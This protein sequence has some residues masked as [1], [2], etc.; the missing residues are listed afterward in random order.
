MDDLARR[1]FAMV[2]SALFLLPLGM[3]VPREAG[4]REV[5]RF[6][7]DAAGFTVDVV[8]PGTVAQNSLV[9]PKYCYVV[10][11]SFQVS[12]H[13]KRDMRG[14]EDLRLDL[15]GDG[16]FEW[17]F[18]STGAGRFGLQDTIANG[19]DSAVL[20]FASPGTQ[21]FMV[22]LPAG[23]AVMNATVDVTGMMEDVAFKADRVT[24]QRAFDMLGLAVAGVGDLNR[25]GYDDVAVGAPGTDSKTFTDNGLF[26][27][28]YGSESGPQLGT[29]D[30]VVGSETGD[31][32]G[33]SL[34][35]VRDFNGDGFGEV[36]VGAPNATHRGM[37]TPTPNTGVAYLYANDGTKLR[38]LPA[39][40]IPGGSTG[41]QMGFSV[42]ELGDVDG[43]G[44]L[45]IGAGEIFANRSVIQPLVGRVGVVPSGPSGVG[46]DLWGDTAYSFFGSFITQA[47]DLDSD[48]KPDFVVGAK[49]NTPSGGVVGRAFVYLSGQDFKNPTVFIG[50]QQLANFSASGATGDFNGD[51]F[52]D[53]ALGA[54]NFTVDGHNV[55]A[56]FIYPGTPR[57]P[58][59]GAKPV[60]LLGRANNSGYG[61]SVASPGDLD[62]DGTDD[63]LV[64]IPRLAKDMFAAPL[65]ALDLILT[66]R[67]RTITLWGEAPNSNFGYS[68]DGAGDVNRDGFRDIIVGAPTHTAGS[69]DAAGLA[70]IFTSQIAAPRN[71]RINVG[72]VGADDWAWPGAFART[73]RTPDMAKKFNG[74]LS[75]PMP[76]TVDD[77]GNAFVE[78]PV[79][80]S[81]DRPG[82]VVISN[83]SIVYNW[84]ATVDVNPNEETG[85]LTWALNNI[86]YP[87][88]MGSPPDIEIP[89]VFNSSSAGTVSVH[90]LSVLIDESPVAKPEFTVEL[91]EDSSDA[92]LVDLFTVFA[93]DF[94]SPE[95]LTFW[96]EGYTNDTLVAVDITDWRWLS[97]DAFNGSANDNWTGGVRIEVSAMDDNWLENYTNITVVVTP[98]N[99]PPEITGMP[100]T[101]AT[102]GAPYSYQMAA[103]D[104]ENDTLAF[105]LASGPAGMSVDGA[106]G[107]VKWTPNGEQYNR[108]F[109]V[110][111]FASDGRLCATQSFSI[112]VS[113]KLEGVKIS[114]S[115]PPTAVVGQEYRYRPNATT[116]V[117]GAAVVLSLLQAPAGMVIQAD[118]SLRWV[119]SES[120]LGAFNIT[121]SASDGSFNATLP[122]TVRVFPAG[123]PVSGL[124]C[125]IQE[126]VEG[127]KVSGKLTVMGS[128]G[129]V[130]GTVMR[131]ELS[132]DG[133]NWKAATG[134]GSW[135]YVLDTT[136][137]SNG[138]HT[139]RARA[140]DGTVYSMNASVGVEVDNPPVSTS[141]S[142]W[143]LPILLIIA[144]V[145]AA[146]V[147]A[148]LYT[149]RGRTAAQAAPAALSAPAV[150]PS[151]PAMARTGEEFAV[152]D[153]FLIN[154]DGRLIHHATR[155]LATGV[156]SDIL[157]S[158]LT[159]VNSFV[160][161]ALVRTGDGQLGS[162]EFGENKII[163]ERGKACYLAVVITGRQEPPELREEMRQAL[164]NVES[165]YGSA[166][167]SWD[168]NAAT[169]SGVKKF[170]GPVTAFSL[171]A[172]PAGPAKAAEVDVAVAGELEFYQGYVRLKV[173]VKNSSPSFIMDSALSVMYNDKALR[174][175]RLEPEY[176]LS[177]REIM[178]GNI[179]I[180][181]KKTVALY[182]DPQICTESYVEATLTFKDA[183]GELHHADM[184]RKLASVVCPIMHTDEN[185]NL[186]MLRR[187]LEGDLDQKDSKV[188]N[189]PPALTPEAAFELCKRAVQGHDIRLVREFSD[190]K[191]FVGEAWYFGKVKG[192]EEKLVVKTAVRAE[193]GS[194]EFYVASN[195]KLVVTGLLAELKNDLNKEY[196]KEKGA[197]RPLEAMA[198]EG[199]RER[200]R[201]A[202]LLLEKYAQGEMAP[203]TTRP[204]EPGR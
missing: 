57:G 146:A 189:L 4:A 73:V 56:V 147:V 62:A 165:E 76:E 8:P 26:T 176:P 145:A 96:I 200:V 201:T 89:L 97:V 113:S 136:G 5:A 130:A 79:T 85:N 78:I 171:S 126:P 110:V 1:A 164:R 61:T 15:N 16:S 141:A 161:D 159:A 166:L 186:P 183:Q 160:K 6:S 102:A 31:F 143:L 152:E 170:L 203:G 58:D 124:T 47:R 125:A 45:D 184:K 93:D 100:P 94:Q 119:P 74:V 108:D 98:V 40:V 168:G 118:G 191:P 192:R 128:A 188:F 55:G 133:R 167:S 104:A 174:L 64:G 88:E 117:A 180:R 151:P 2:I 163:L 105:G 33:F 49:F 35:G 46:T 181:E 162:L 80:V 112:A 22:R 18:N 172:P 179:G 194:A 65:G 53:L 132:V 198:D 157:S 7:D 69:V 48:K 19:S 91:P 23:A 10:N 86:L 75:N 129:I 178:L 70:T 199:R 36:L 43:D 68:V 29:G 103:R 175:E 144:I 195:S 99:D 134:T 173:A 32:L 83:I 82:T 131:V 67:N 21:T 11:S 28:Y 37:G 90:D 153:V 12:T 95:D 155:R 17:A 39:R 87:H 122:W 42:G 123:T 177:G 169:L 59:P 72:G 154:L 81:S 54:P 101:V 30:T 84:T 114:G 27:V 38:P 187:M 156:D 50:P 142:G 13:A 196:R 121:L 25:D 24:G 197:E 63:L 150:L 107:L 116:D 41:G 135:S 139:L 109:D 14:I 138:R 193:T 120:Q 182:L 185:I 190:D 92:Y 111:L 149:R 34:S 127:K 137:L 3:L 204:P 158:M 77:F 148:L 140:W 60:I 66:G 52:E 115:P 106:T 202:G 71:P 20:R 51:G 44:T 9:L